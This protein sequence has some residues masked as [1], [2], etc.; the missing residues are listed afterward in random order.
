MQLFFITVANVIV[1]LYTIHMYE[2]CT[3]EFQKKKIL[4]FVMFDHVAINRNHH[5][6]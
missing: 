4:Y 3:R 6:Q 2:T 1:T 5:S